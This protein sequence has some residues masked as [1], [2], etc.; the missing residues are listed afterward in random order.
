M[1]STAGRSLWVERNSRRICLLL[2]PSHAPSHRRT[3]VPFR[4]VWWKCKCEDW[5]VWVSLFC[6][7]ADGGKTLTFFNNDYKGEFQTVTFE[8]PEIKK[9]FY[10]SFHKVRFIPVLV[11][12]TDWLS[13]W[14]TDLIDLY[15]SLCETYMSADS[16]FYWSLSVDNRHKLCCD[17]SLLVVSSCARDSMVQSK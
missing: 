1:S 8:G 14:L 6:L 11:R 16:C 2:T 17:K 15:F 12:L 10:G 13:E 9:L 3:F 7:P 4:C 5:S